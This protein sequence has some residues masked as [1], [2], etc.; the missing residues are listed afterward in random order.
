MTIV[1]PAAAL[2]V[3]AA[4]GLL[5]AAGPDRARRRELPYGVA[6]L[7]V[8]LLA[9]VAPNVFVLALIALAAVLLQARL[10]PGGLPA[11]APALAAGLLG[12]TGYAAQGGSANATRL[13]ALACA[14]AIAG[15]AGVMP[16]LGPLEPREGRPAGSGLAWSAFMGP[17]LAVAVFARAG[18]LLPAADQRLLG[19]LL[20]A[21]G[22]LNVAWGLGAAF[23]RGGEDARRGSVL[24]DWGFALIGLG[25]LS[26]D[27]AAASY[28]LLLSLVLVRLPWL[29]GHGRGGRLTA[30]ALGGSPPFAGFP[31]RLLLLRAATA[32][33]WPFAL[34]LALAMALALPA[35]LR[36]PHS[37][38]RGRRALA[39]EALTLALGAVIG[40]YPELVLR[41]VGLA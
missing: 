41:P 32:I 39:G 25:L 5:L 21:I 3:A 30:L 11:P 12:V 28:L 15:L 23:A 13:A 33:A 20:L 27:G 36:L 26:R 34:A 7:L 31:G 4:A 37:G 8:G 40:I 17:A 38:R 29:L 22:A 18:S 24:S 9:A 16:L 1:T 19:G 10:R 35:S 2:A 14:L 6:G